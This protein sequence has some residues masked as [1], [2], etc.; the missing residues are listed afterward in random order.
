MRLTLFG[1]FID[2]QTMALLEFLLNTWTEQLQ[3]IKYDESEML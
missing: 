2:A 1:L 3:R